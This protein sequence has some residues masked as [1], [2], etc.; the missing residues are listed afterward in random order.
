MA[1]QGLGSSGLCASI[2][3]DEGERWEEAAKPWGPI[4]CNLYG[5]ESRDRGQGEPPH[6][7]QAC[8][9]KEGVED[10]RVW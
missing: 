2:R 10:L 1:L 5:D 7:A 3:L 9:A 6:S 8:S 4:F